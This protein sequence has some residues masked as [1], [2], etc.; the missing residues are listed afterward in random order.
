MSIY[1]IECSDTVNLSEYA[2]TAYVNQRMSEQR[3]IVTVWA[4]EKGNFERGAF[5]WSFGNGS[6]GRQHSLSG[7]TMMAPGR[8]LR[9]GL[10]TD[11]REKLLR[12]D[13]TVNGRTFDGLHIEKPI[14]THSAVNVFGEQSKEVSQ[15]DRI[16]FKTTQRTDNKP[17]CGVVTLL[18]ELEI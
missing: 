10:A 8:I 18:I 6:D 16:N 15:G 7:Y 14:G 2:K 3:P 9:A 17:G 11:L 5:E 13:I 4:E 12:V 1:G